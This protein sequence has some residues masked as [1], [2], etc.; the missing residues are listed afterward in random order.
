MSYEWRQNR[1]FPEVFDLYHDGGYAHAWVIREKDEAMWKALTF[2][3]SYG[4]KFRGRYASVQD[5]KDAV[6]ANI[7]ERRL[8]GKTN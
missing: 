4:Q 2:E 8:D 5:A 1:M 6:I 3:V 7:V